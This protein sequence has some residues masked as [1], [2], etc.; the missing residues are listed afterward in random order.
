MQQEITIVVAMTRNRVIGRDNA[1]PWHLPADLKQFKRVTMGKPIIMGRKTFDSIGCA[2]PGR[3]NVVLTR[4]NNWSSPGVEVFGSLSQAI[5]NFPDEPE[6]M[7]IGG[8][9]VYQQAL[10]LATKIILTEIDL[11]CEGDTFFPDINESEWKRKSQHRC[12]KDESNQYHYRF[13]ELVRCCNKAS[14]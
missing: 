13:V 4:N 1:M 6:L 2:L 9:T 10:P 12:L 14:I 7:I 5:A 8:A 11:E 3:T